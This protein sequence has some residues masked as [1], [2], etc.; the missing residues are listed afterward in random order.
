MIKIEIKENDR[1]QRLDRFLKKYLPGAGL[2]K[3]Y[4]I[5]RKDL[6]I[7]GKRGRIDQFLEKGD[8]L[9]LYLSSEEAERLGKKKRQYTGKKQFTVAYED[10]DM[11]IVNK[12]LGL[13]THGD[14]KE[15]KDTLANQVIGYLIAKGDY[16]PQREQSFIPAPVNRLDRN[17]TGLLIFGKNRK[18]IQLLNQGIQDKDQIKKTYRTIVCGKLTRNQEIHHKM[19]KDSERNRVSIVDPEVPGKEMAMEVRPIQAGR[20]YTLVEVSLLTGRSHQ[21]RVQLAAIGHPIIGDHK[22]GNPGINGR[23]KK[24]YHLNTHLLHAGGLEIRW[25]GEERPREVKSPL[26][27]QFTKMVEFLIEGD[28]LVETGVFTRSKT[29]E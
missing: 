14:G 20:E 17:T 29:K 28:N 22:Y 11:I 19:Q 23:L 6:K 10:E 21:I 8:Q 18:A 3:I 25:Q 7:N 12:P 16:V 4:R 9:I 26:P 1:G 24:Q 27:P 13:L 15:K 2:G 5:I